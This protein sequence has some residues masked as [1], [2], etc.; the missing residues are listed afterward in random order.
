MAR[1][2]PPISDALPYHLTARCINKEWFRIPLLEVWQIMGDYLFFIHH[3]YDVEILQF[4]LMANHFHLT[5]RFPNKNLSRSM[6]YFMR[7]TSRRIT[8]R[9][10]RVNQTYGARFHRSLITSERHYRNVY[11]YIYRN[12]VRAG[13]CQRVEEYSF[14]TLRGVLGGEKLH[15]PLADDTLL[16]CPEVQ[17]STLDWLNTDPGEIK[18]DEM[19]RALKKPILRFPERDPRTKKPTLLLSEEY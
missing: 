5:I 16:F 15:I 7:E 1:V 19:R 9:A 4:V 2:H 17:E 12:P 18:R 8:S 3:A 14:S 13:L 6:E 11:K 10:G